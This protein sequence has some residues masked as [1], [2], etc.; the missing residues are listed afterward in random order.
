MSTLL[1]RCWRALG[2]I[3]ITVIVCFLL[4][5]NLGLGYFSLRNNL[6]LFVPM[7]NLGLFRWIN[8]YGVANPRHAAWFFAMII[9]LGALSI[10]TFVCTTERVFQILA[11]RYP[12]RELPFHFAPHLMHYAVLIILGGYLC[13]YLFA[14]SDTGHALR[15]GQMLRLENGRVTLRFIDFKPEILRSKR[16]DSFDGYVIRPNAQLTVNDG[17]HEYP[18]V[19]NFNAPLRVAGYGIYLSEFQPRRP[20]GGMGRSYINLTVRRDPSAVIYRFGM[21]VFVLGLGLYVFGR[22]FSK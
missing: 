21:A 3:R 11:R 13:S 14:T 19:L 1:L 9:L 22:K 17:G 5:A 2:N 7:S 8:T 15:P 20:G 4:T 16:V 10:N 12:V 6:E 18:A